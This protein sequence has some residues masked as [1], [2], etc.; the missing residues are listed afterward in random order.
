[1]YKIINLAPARTSQ[2]H[3]AQI[4]SYLTYICHF[5]LNYKIKVLGKKISLQLKYL[6]V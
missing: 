5:K 4:C 2:S 3:D 6:G 1:M